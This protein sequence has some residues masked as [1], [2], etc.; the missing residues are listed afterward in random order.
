MQT[1]RYIVFLR[2]ILTLALTTVGGPHSHLTVILKILVKKR[3]Y[4]TEEELMELYALCQV[5]PGPASTQT[6]TAVGYKIG[7]AKLAYLTLLVWVLPS[8][9]IMSAAAILWQYYSSKDVY[10]P[11]TKYIEPLAVG[12]VAYAAWII[13]LK[14][15]KTI[16]GIWL[17]ILSSIAG[18]FLRSPYLTPIFILAGGLATT[19]KYKSIAN[20]STV[21]MVVKWHNFFVFIGVFIVAFLIGVLTKSIPVKLFESFYRN[22]SLIFGGGQVLIPLIHTEYVT[23]KRYLTSEEFLTGYALV[24]AI[25]GPLFSISSYIG[26]A[27]M[28][29]HGIVGQIL[30]AVVATAGIFLPGTFLIFFVYR[31]WDTLKKNRFIKAATEGIVAVS[32]GLVVGISLFLFTT[33]EF[34]FTNA[35]VVVVTFVCL[36][37]ERIPSLVLILTAMALG[38]VL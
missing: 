1:L 32:A 15:I 2:D 28:K 5:L 13:S 16:D 19:Y 7:G 22:G 24:S 33:I 12:F 27:A 18:Y 34:N 3:G 36:L 30:G 10:L 35:A 38:Y 26:A 8:M 14:V 23:L 9:C 4:L 21:K 17:L 29:H 31:F 37:S 25:P 6:I 11:F 20:E